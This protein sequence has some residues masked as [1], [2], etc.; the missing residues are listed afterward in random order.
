MKH[1]SIIKEEKTR[2]KSVLTSHQDNLKRRI[3]ASDYFHTL[4]LKKT[5]P[6]SQI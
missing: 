4:V 6:G 3:Y 5:I 2:K 1:I